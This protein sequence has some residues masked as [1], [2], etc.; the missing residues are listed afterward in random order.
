MH[1][2]RLELKNFKRFAD[3]RIEGIPA[4]T[5]LV[6]LIGS[7]GSGKSSVFDAFECLNKASK[8]GYDWPM[9]DYYKKD[10]AQPFEVNVDIE[11]GK[12]LHVDADMFHADIRV[13]GYPEVKP[14]AFYGRS[15]FRQIP[16]L[17]RTG[18]GQN[19]SD[20]TQDADRPRF[21]I[22]R[23]ERLE[24]DIEKITVDILRKVFGGAQKGTAFIENRILS[25]INDAFG[26]IFGNENGTKLRLLEFIPPADRKL[27]EVNFQKGN[28]KFH[29]NQL[30]AGEKEVFNVLLN[31]LARQEYYQD[32]VYFFDELDLHLNTQIQYALLKE[33]TEHWLPDNCQLWTA[34]HSLGF[35]QYAK[36]FE[37]AVIIDFDD[38]DFDNPVILVP[39]PKDN[40]DVYEIAVGKQ[41]LPLL[42]ENFNICF[43]ENN[44]KDFYAE[45]NIPKTIFVPENNR[46][47]V[48][49]KVKTGQ[50]KGLVDR[51]F[52]SDSD[53]DLIEQ[54]YPNL[55]ILRLYS[56]ENYLY[57]PDN[58]VEYHQLKNQ[59]FDREQYI[60]DLTQ[61]KNE[62]KDKLMLG[63]A[64]VRTGYAYFSEPE[65][66]GTAEQKRFKNSKENVDQT[67]LVSTDLDSNS[68]E[69]FYKVLPM[70]DNCTHLS[71]RQNIRPSDLAKTVWFRSQVL[72][73]IR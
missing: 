8:D 40:P 66:N 61:A 42:F 48:Y 22:D 24:N 29:Y 23:D 20:T 41:F 64:L 19:S 58:L 52:L 16:R 15:S 10:L 7:N 55:R 27:A 9:Q 12:H 39:Q 70:K 31:L 57:H 45:A 43:V 1:I 72:Q 37:Q 73:L 32:T 69:D 62:I 11:G 36:D 49:H 13:I 17:T 26:R 53:I 56:I 63:V 68:L 4:D 54:H 6:L 34:S 38:L 14:D 3:L 44:D 65:W 2:T 28:S 25:P 50:Y 30:S 59:P 67:H 47:A 21:Y 46:N 33:I 5:K 18:L 71:Q 60:R 35:I 51:D